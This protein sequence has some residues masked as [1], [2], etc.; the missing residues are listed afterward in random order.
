M[1]LST[2]ELDQLEQFLES[3]N[4]FGWDPLPLDVMQ[5]FLCGVAS[6]PFALDNDDWLAPAL[7]IEGAITQDAQAKIWVQLLTR[8]FDQQCAALEGR[9]DAALIFLGEDAAAHTP[10]AWSNW[11]LGFCEAFD[12]FEAPTEGL[13]DSPAL[14]ELMFPLRALADP[15]AERKRNHMNAPQWQALLHD[16]ASELWPTVLEVYR[17]GLAQRKK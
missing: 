13:L 1:P 4:P 10:E 14:Q 6:L 8:Y 2:K 17:H 3:E 9:E 7:G 16:C 12:I 5:G 11:C 15:Q